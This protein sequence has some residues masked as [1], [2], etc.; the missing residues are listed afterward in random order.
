MVFAQ[1]IIWGHINCCTILEKDY[2]WLNENGNNISINIVYERIYVLKNRGTSHLK[3]IF[4]KTQLL[5]FNYALHRILNSYDLCTP[6]AFFFHHILYKAFHFTIFVK[7]Y[8]M[9]PYIEPQYF[10]NIICILHNASCKLFSFIMLRILHITPS[11]RFIFFIMHTMP[12]TASN[13]KPLKIPKGKAF[14]QDCAFPRKMYF[15][16][17]VCTKVHTRTQHF[18]ANIF[19]IRQG[20]IRR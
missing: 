12:S 8:F 20:T 10:H 19:S 2:V 5:S 13:N 14:C 11:T 4:T 1:K 7:I 16:I 9:V 17:A 15:A 6:Y 18:T 3:K